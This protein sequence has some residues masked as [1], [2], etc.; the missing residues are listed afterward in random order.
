MTP[1]VWQARY[2]DLRVRLDRLFALIRERGYHEDSFE[3][4]R[5][6]ATVARDHLAGML[7]VEAP[8]RLPRMYCVPLPRTFDWRF[9]SCDDPFEIPHPARSVPFDDETRLL[10]RVVHVRDEGPGAGAP[11]TIRLAIAVSNSPGRICV[12]D[13]KGRWV[14]WMRSTPPPGVVHPDVERFYRCTGQNGL[15]NDRDHVQEDVDALTAQ[16]NDHCRMR[17][18]GTW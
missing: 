17:M 3:R 14:L 2:T 16:F 1:S 13:Q 6:I 5:F 9:D 15:N 18:E 8:S 11:H 4:G 7:V 12:A 10:L